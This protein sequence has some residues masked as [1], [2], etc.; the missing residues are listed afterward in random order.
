MEILESTCQKG[1]RR[2]ARQLE[3]TN[4]EIMIERTKLKKRRAKASPPTR[5]GGPPR[6][7]RQPERTVK[8]IENGKKQFQ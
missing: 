4:K 6:R 5:E 8:N 3:V 1:P 7:A 2:R